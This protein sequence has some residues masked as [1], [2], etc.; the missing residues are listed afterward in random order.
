MRGGVAM[1][2]LLS[3]AEPITRMIPE[4]FQAYLKWQHSWNE[5]GHKDDEHGQDLD[6][7]QL[8]GSS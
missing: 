4:Y 7:P 3:L 1:Q 6:C 2:R 8:H 5:N